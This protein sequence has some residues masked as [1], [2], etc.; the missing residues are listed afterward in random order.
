MLGKRVRGALYVH[1]D[2][3][4]LLRSP[5]LEIVE[6]A[7]SCAGECPWNVARLESGVVGLLFYE[8]FHTD[9]FPALRASTRVDLVTGHATL[10]RFNGPNPLILHRKEL[11]LS[12]DDPRVGL[13]SKLTKALETEG[14]FRDPHLIGRHDSWARRLAEAG[15]R[16]DGHTLCP[17]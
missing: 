6:R 10:R 7:E 3:V 11:L 9:P 2:A 5:A 17:T 14:V 8:A 1:R 4:R 12:P 15:L 16:L 13:W